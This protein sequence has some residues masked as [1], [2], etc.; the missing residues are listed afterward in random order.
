MSYTPESPATVPTDRPGGPAS[1]RIFLLGAPRLQ[2]CDGVVHLL[3]R[4][5]AA[6]LTLLAQEGPQ[7]HA[8]AC[9]LLWP[10]VGD[11][12]ARANLRQRLFRLRRTARRDVVLSP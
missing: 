3:E 2:C 12:Q 10:D 6:L 1:L 11:G 8:T 9:A 4:K 5:D 7:Q